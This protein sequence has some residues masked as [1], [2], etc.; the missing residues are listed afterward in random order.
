MVHSC[1]TFLR[2]QLYI[3]SKKRIIILP[4]VCEIYCDDFD[5]GDTMSCLLFCL[6]FVDE[7]SQSVIIDL[8]SDDAGTHT[9]NYQHSN[10]SFY[11]C[12]KK[13]MTQY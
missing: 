9:I 12:L 7:A 1:R 10:A 13:D 2:S 3:D 6:Q 11:R 5:K 4:K 8:I